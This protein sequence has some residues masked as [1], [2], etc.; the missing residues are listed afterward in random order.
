MLGA[1]ARLL[2]LPEEELRIVLAE[3][4]ESRSGETAD[5]ILRLFDAGQAA[6]RNEH[7]VDEFA[8]A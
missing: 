5:L 2:P 7:L 8:T 6:A 4:F 3:W 1:A